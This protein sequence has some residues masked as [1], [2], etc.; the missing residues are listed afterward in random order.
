MS[1]A[2]QKLSDRLNLS[3]PYDWS[4]PNPDHDAFI[5]SVLD[6]C[7]LEDIVKCVHYFG[8]ERI[9]LNYTQLTNTVSL[10][11]AGRQIKAIEGVLNEFVQRDAT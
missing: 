10:T 6:R 2:P 4:N 1:I 5:L 3:F 11:I 7:C 9:K 8:L